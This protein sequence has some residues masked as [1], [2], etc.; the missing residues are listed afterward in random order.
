MPFSDFL[1]PDFDRQIRLLIMLKCKTCA[2]ENAFRAFGVLG[3]AVQSTK[4]HDCLIVY[5][6]RVLGNKLVGQLRVKFLATRRSDVLID[7]KNASE[8]AIYIAIHDRD[9]F[10][11]SERCNGGGCIV[12][13]ARK[14]L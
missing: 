3:Q 13:D 9:A 14:C 1:L 11:K 7:P 12:S 8:Y 5:T 2:I 4:F 6:G 10:T